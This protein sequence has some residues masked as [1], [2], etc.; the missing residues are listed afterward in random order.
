MS[1]QLI[2]DHHVF[3]VLGRISKLCNLL[4]IRVQ[5]YLEDIND[6]L[7]L[8]CMLALANPE[9]DYTV[10]PSFLTFL[11]KGSIIDE[12][13]VQEL[14]DQAKKYNLLRKGLTFHYVNEIMEVLDRI[15]YK[16]I[17]VIRLRHISS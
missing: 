9:T 16:K 8:R 6:D 11:S 13:M 1:S 10:S 12:Q 3:T 17:W 7:E 2:A 5:D 15:G 14:L 4:G